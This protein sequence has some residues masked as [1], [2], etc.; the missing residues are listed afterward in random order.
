MYQDEY[1]TNLLYYNYKSLFYQVQLLKKRINPLTISYPNQYHSAQT[2]KNA[3]ADRKFMQFIDKNRSI[4]VLKVLFAKILV[5]KSNETCYNST[6]GIFL[7]IYHGRFLR[8]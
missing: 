5:E 1:I 7:P 8:L 4:T 3:F 6:H 2:H